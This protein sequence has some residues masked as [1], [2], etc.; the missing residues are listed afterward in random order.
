MQHNDL[1]I[2]NHFNEKEI[3]IAA[4]AGVDDVIP[5]DECVESPL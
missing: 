5:V 2:F 4:A 1:V 3:L